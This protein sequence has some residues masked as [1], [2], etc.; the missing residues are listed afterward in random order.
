MKITV[1]QALLILLAKYRNNAEKYNELKHLYLAGAKNET[2]R[3]A[4]DTYL[5][6]P[7]L[8]EFQISKAPEDITHDSSRRYFETHLAY[9]TL[10]SK[11][12]KLT[13]A[14][15]NQHLDAVKGTAYSSYADLYEE[16]LQGEYSPSDT[17]EREYADYLTKLQKKEIF[18]EFTE[19][20]RQKISAIVSAAFVAMIVASQ[21][22]HLLPL[23][24]YGEGIYLERGKATKENQSK[25]TTSA[26]GLLQSSDPVPLDDPARMTQI[27]E[28][29]KPSEQST[30][31]PNAQWVKD[32]FSRLV[33]PFSNSISGTM[34]CQIRALAKIQELKKLA[35]YMAALAKP[36]DESAS[37]SK[38]IDEATKK[39]QIDLVLSIM[40]S[41][42]V[43]NEVL[44]K[45]AEL[46]NKGQISYEVIDHI[47]KRLMRPFYHPQKNWDHS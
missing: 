43:T 10:S 11:L 20:Q 24:I 5:Q 19:E 13:P 18:A 22:P 21:G 28:F 30:Y 12:E 46:I 35:D 17:T 4:I 34:L 1:G 38:A 16:V 47:K 7:A 37:A 32:N 26:L 33:H 29:L 41:G 40:E 25:T 6:D 36:T 14:E 9:E 39:N 3:L 8:A 44:A 31:D 15:I 42:K 2:T 27:Q 23:D 45:A